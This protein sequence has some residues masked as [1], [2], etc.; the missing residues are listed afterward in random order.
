MECKD[1]LRKTEMDRAL[2]RWKKDALAVY[3]SWD[4]D[5]KHKKVV[6]DRFV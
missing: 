2:P 1:S 4:D 6:G 3:C 5:T